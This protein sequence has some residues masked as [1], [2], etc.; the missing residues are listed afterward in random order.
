PAAAG[1]FR[2]HFQRRLGAAEMIDEFA[3]GDRTD[4]VAADQPQPGDPLSF[5]QRN[6][7]CPCAAVVHGYP[8][9]PILLSVP[10]IKRPILARCFH[11]VITVRTAKSSA[12]FS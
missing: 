3:E 10:F 7:P 5:R 6:S 1:E 4:I 9:L 2:Q 11:Q 8:L 12:T